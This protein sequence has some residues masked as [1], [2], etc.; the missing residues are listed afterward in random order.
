MKLLSSQSRPPTIRAP[1]LLVF[2]SYLTITVALSS[3]LDGALSTPT[4][5]STSSSIPVAQVHQQYVDLQEGKHSDK[6]VSIRVVVREVKQTSPRLTFLRVRDCQE[7]IDNDSST[8]GSG[9]GQK[10]DNP[11]KHEIELL[12]R[13]RDG[14]LTRSEIDQIVEKTRDGTTTLHCRAFPEKLSLFDG[15]SFFPTTSITTQSESV[16]SA[17]CLHVV[18]ANVTT[19]S[20]ELLQLCPIER[21]QRQQE[22]SFGQT[23]S[24]S[25]MPGR[26]PPL[27]TPTTGQQQQNQSKKGRGGGRNRDRGGIFAAWALEIFGTAHMQHDTILD[28]AGG[29]GQLAFQFG[30]RRGMNITVVDPRSLRLASDQQRTL[31]Y[32]RQQ[33]L[34]LIPEGRDPSL[35]SSKYGHHFCEIGPPPTLSS[36]SGRRFEDDAFGLSTPQQ[37]EEKQQQQQTPQEENNRNDRTWLVG[38]EAYVRHLAAWFD[39]TFVEPPSSSIVDLSSSASRRL[40]TSAIWRDCT[41]VLGM[42]TDE[43]TEDLV[44]LALAYDKPFAVVPCCVFWKRHPNRKTPQG[45]AV[46]TWEQFCEYLLAKGDTGNEKPNRIQVATLSFPGR[47]VVL[48]SLGAEKSNSS[49]HD[50]L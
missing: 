29:A 2:L 24:G 43:A 28:V 31:K 23:V 40:T 11:I 8:S 32:H 46:R 22:P 27:T 45:K 9:S 17:V 16:A 47:N 15:P 21:P 1:V 50:R 13:E 30:V 18:S 26:M 44:D 33:G 37:G 14:F 20:G 12:L 48:Y 35:P 38:G 34:R 41:V 42:H 25:P 7:I 4:T 10:D 3:S 19:A 39:P 6:R 36:L 5:T 49:N